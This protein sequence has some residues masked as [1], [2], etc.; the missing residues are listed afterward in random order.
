MGYFKDNFTVWLKANKNLQRPRQFAGYMD[1][2][3]NNLLTPMIGSDTL[4]NDIDKAIHHVNGQKKVLEALDLL[5]DFFKRLHAIAVNGGA[6]SAKARTILKQHNIKPSNTSSWTSVI[7]AYELFMI[8]LINNGS[9]RSS[10]THYC[11]TPWNKDIDKIKKIE[12]E[13]LA[14][15][16]TDS[17]LAHFNNQADA[18]ISTVMRDSFFFSK[19]DAEKRFN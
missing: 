17:L 8:D 13:V 5:Y 3:A 7:D 12:S 10:S 11:V 9:V 14:F 4:I 1:A 18:F 15:N 6:N 19:K 2:I 16:G